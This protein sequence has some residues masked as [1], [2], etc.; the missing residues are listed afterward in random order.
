MARAKRQPT[1]P[2]K[3]I[4]EDYLKRHTS[5]FMPVL[6][7]AFWL[8][9]FSRAFNSLMVDFTAEYAGGEIKINEAEIVDTGWF[10][11]D[12]LPRTPPRLPL[13]GG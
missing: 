5:H 4:R 6:T 10:S 9:P 1:H 12:N 11:A 3:I 8:T 2:G 13:P 7:G